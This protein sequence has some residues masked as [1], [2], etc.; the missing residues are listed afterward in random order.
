MV[1]VVL[2]SSFSHM[3]NMTDG[4]GVDGRSGVDG[5]SPPPLAAVR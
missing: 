2:H 3:S 5:G 1:R 4:S